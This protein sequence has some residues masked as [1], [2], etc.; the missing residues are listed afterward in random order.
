MIFMLHAIIMV[1]ATMRQTIVLLV[2]GH[3]P[4]TPAMLVVIVRLIAGNMVKVSCF[5]VVV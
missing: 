2:L 5:I 4:A 3:A 1:N